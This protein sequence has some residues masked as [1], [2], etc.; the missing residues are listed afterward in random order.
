MNHRRSGAPPH[1]VQNGTDSKLFTLDK[2]V[3]LSRKIEIVYG[4][5]P[6]G[7][8]ATVF[9]STAIALFLA[10]GSSPL[11][12]VYW[13]G[14]M[15]L[16]IL[17]RLADFLAY[18]RRAIDLNN[19]SRW[20]RSFL[21]GVTSQGIL[22]GIGGY[23]LFPDSPLDQ[24]FLV[25][26]FGGMAGGALIFLSPIWPA[27]IIY[28]ATLMVPVCLRLL[29]A[30]HPAYWMTGFMLFAYLFSCMLISVKTRRWID[31]YLITS[32]EKEALAGNLQTACSAL[33]GYRDD[34]E[35][36]VDERT[37]ELSESNLQLQ[38][39]IHEK[40]AEKLKAELSE[41]RFRE[42]AE[43]LPE[44]IFETD[45]EGALSFLNR[46]GGELTGLSSDP[47]PTGVR[48]PDIFIP[49]DRKHVEENLERLI[50]GEAIEPVEFTALRSDGTTFPVLTV[51]SPIVRDGVAC[52]LR[53]I[54]MDTTRI[55]EL[56][57]SLRHAQKMEAVGQLAGGIAHDFNNI[58]TA[59]YGYCAI[60][61]KKM[62]EG[63]P[64]IPD[65]NHICTSAERAANLTRSLLAFSR[66]Q[67]M[68]TKM[69]NLNDV[70]MNVWQLLTRIIGEDIHIKMIPAEKPLNIL[71]DSG[72]IE[73]VLMNLAANARDAMPNG[74]LLTIETEA[75]EI[76]ESFIHAHGL[77]VSGKYAVISVS[78]T[79]TGM[80]AET[81]KKIFE[82][83]FTTKEVGKGTGLGLSIIYGIINQ[84]NGYINVYSEPDNGTTFKIYIPQACEE[85]KDNK[86]EA[87]SEYP[88][89][90]SET[91]LLVEDDPSILQLADLILRKFGYEVILAEDGAE[92]VEKFN[93]YKEKIAIIVM[94]MIMPRKSGKE[95]Y[96]EIR[97]VRP[98]IKTLFMSGYSPDL[99][100]NKGI[101]E[102]GEEV[103]I[104]PFQPLDLVRKV[105]SV[106]DLTSRT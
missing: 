35:R 88:R 89:M 106:L 93:T 81:S 105:R 84:H 28:S 102:T 3:L 40:D 15:A 64:F 59:I 92:A 21:A 17:L 38:K 99:L 58:L 51:S 44:M 6:S 98:D 95:A 31:N 104:K 70:V 7:L 79:G 55:K 20:K 30:G 13:G 47:P 63:S 43:L 9:V 14:G 34:L 80:A 57:L 33:E 46:K 29:L 82:P 67:I 100:Q 96:E 37:R 4:Y 56:E 87:H 39:E 62:G 1:V 23:C 27:F 41:A 42:L 74:G 5:L 75:R 53:G 52:G 103:L 2:E 25:S 49:D 90:G 83:F 48:L 54:L 101:L 91:I 77:G 72:Q 78:D 26:T 10:R 12:A 32:L 76:D 16:V 65:I 94:D 86:E 36:L 85:N 8:L 71:A 61:Q 19:P 68:C 22:W 18:R 73:Q 97:K 66:K 69:V 11:S 50:A 60:L 45:R 24:M